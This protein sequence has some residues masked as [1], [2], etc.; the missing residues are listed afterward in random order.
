MTT[1]KQLAANRRNARKC[2]G[3][4][5]QHGKNC[6]RLN[7]LRHG[8]FAESLVLLPGEN[9]DDLAALRKSYRKLYRPANQ[10]EHFLVDRMILATWRLMRLTALEPRIVDVHHQNGE[11]NALRNRELLDMF[12]EIIRRKPSQPST[13]TAQLAFA[14]PVAH[15]YIRD[16]EH[17]NTVSK[18]ARYQT[19]L[20]RSFY[21]ALSQLQ[22][23][24]LLRGIS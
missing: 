21:R 11:S 12:R 1:P 10:T 2:T 9:P 8:A 24:Q 20:E 16:S 4:K 6:S 23:L 3:P 14:D 19:A 22:K 18:L 17:G 15:A 7:A 5:T 13:E